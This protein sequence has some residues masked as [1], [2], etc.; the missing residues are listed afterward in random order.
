MNGC[1]LPAGKLVLSA[2]DSPDPVAEGAP[3]TYAATV[4][5]AGSTLA[6][7]VTVTYALSSLGVTGTAS[8]SQGT[9]A[10][11]GRLVS[12]QLGALA[13]G[14][15]ADVQVTF[16]PTSATPGLSATVSAGSEL[17]DSSPADNVVA[18]TTVVTAAG[19]DIAVIN[20]NNGGPGSLRQAILDSNADAGDR[21]RIVFNIPG[22]GVHTIVPLT[23]LPVIS[24]PAII[25]GTTQPGYSGSPVIELNGNGL[26][27]NGLFILG[28]SI[29]RGLVINRF[30]G[31]GIVVQ[32]GTG[33]AIEGN[34]IGTDA[35]G[36]LD[37][38]N[39][40]DGIQVN[41]ASGTL[42]GGTTAA[43]RNVVSGNNAVGIRLSGTTTGTL[44]RGNY[45]GVD[46]PGFNAIPNT[47]S[48]VALGDTA[49][50]NTI[51]GSA[52]GAGNLI[53]GNGNMGV[54]LFGAGVTGNTVAGNRIGTDDLVDDVDSER[55]PRRQHHRR[56]GQRHRRRR[57]RAEHHLGQSAE[58]RR[59]FRRHGHRQSGAR[60][61]DR[62][63]QQRHERD[64]ERHSWRRDHQRARQHH[65]RRRAGNVISGNGQNGIVVVRRVV[66]RHADR[67]QLD[68][69]RTSRRPA[70]SANRRG[71]HPDRGCAVDGDRGKASPDWAETS[72]AATA[73]A[74]S[75]ST[76]ARPASCL[77]Y[78]HRRQHDRVQRAAR[79][80]RQRPERH[81][82]RDRVQHVHRRPADGR[83]AI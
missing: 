63:Q 65:R 1:G 11:T 39:G 28:G 82:D 37:R 10:I 80:P 32:G 66:G 50:G 16:T 8:S 61:P 75:G 67:R 64:R 71:R 47:G 51:G 42:I 27:N 69:R 18:L 5:N 3:V 43:T 74:A 60:Q 7:Q 19:R 72:S 68:R 20:T 24:Q 45:I 6:S 54:T 58:R 23:A 56:L 14:A 59:H 78:P 2:T 52:A 48:G 49:N 62:H 26:S 21:D 36:T 17:A 44:I 40:G 15:S 77:R 83:R 9:C 30:G 79:I 46:A 35:T 53:S 55:F 81:S 38:G 73:R 76:A 41:G 57:E 25:D 22:T 12:C 70:R 31:A 33:T 29:V 13:P 4:T 34:Y